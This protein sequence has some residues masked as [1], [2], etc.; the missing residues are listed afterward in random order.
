M[1]RYELILELSKKI[2]PRV[3]REWLERIIKFSQEDLN[4][5]LEYYSQK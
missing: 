2:E 3:Y 5:L 4:K 1:N